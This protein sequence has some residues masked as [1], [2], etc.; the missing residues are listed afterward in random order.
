MPNTQSSFE[1]LT[2]DCLHVLKTLPNDSVQCVVT[3]PPYWGLRDYN[4]PYQIGIE[5]TVGGYVANIRAVFREVKRVLR[6]DGTVFLN[7]GD[8]YKNKQLVGVPWKVVFGLQDDGWML[9]SDIIW[10]KPNPIP[11]PVTDRPT[12]SHEYIFLFT[13][14]PDYYY[15]SYAIR[16]VT[17]GIEKN[18]R[19]VWQMSV[20]PY[21]KAHFATFPE[22][23][24]RLC[25]QAG[26]SH[27]GACDRCGTPW[28]RVIDK[29]KLTR[30]RPH[31]YVKRTGEKGTGNKC[32]NS[33][34]GVKIHTIGWS[35]SCMCPT[36]P[37]NRCVVLDPFCGSGTS[38]A[39][40]CQLG[41]DF[42][43]IELNPEYIKLARDRITNL[44]KPLAPTEDVAGQA[45]MFET[46]S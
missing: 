26:T 1:L 3:S 20:Q 45:T 31:D 40:A 13:K 2:G 27:Y 32:A 16:D 39:V 14:S 5:R 24:P 25:I 10:A 44:K 17:T 33:V 43:G 38:G 34:A 19:T 11:E 21:P 29:E 9:R 28:V 18:R 35:Q 4:N 41:R 8:T 30:K 12:R 36:A 23:L 37:V 42:I 7:Y 6:K 46:E 15:D 22:Q